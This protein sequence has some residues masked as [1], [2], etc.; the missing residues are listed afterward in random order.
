MVIQLPLESRQEYSEP[1]V[2]KRV[3]V[4]MVAQGSLKYKVSLIV[5]EKDGPNALRGLHSA[6][7]FR[8]DSP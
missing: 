8:F 3:N 6:P 2:D 1:R 7:E 4:C 5:A